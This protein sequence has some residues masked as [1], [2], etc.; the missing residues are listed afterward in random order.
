MLAIIK[1]REGGSGCYT[2]TTEKYL[3]L[4]LLKLGLD[5]A[6]F[7]LCCQKLYNSFLS[8][9][10]SFLSLCSLSII[11]ADLALVIFMANVWFLGA[12]RS[13]VSPCFL[14]ANATATYGALPL[15]M[16][17][18]GVLDYCLEDT[19]L[20]N[21]SAFCKFLRNAVLTLLVWMLAVIHSFGS[22]KAQLIELDYVTG[23]NVQVC[24]IEDSP[25]I[26]YFILGL[27]TAVTCT[28]LPFWSRI[29][30]W[31]KEANR[32]SEEREEQEN[33]KSDLLFTSS[34][35]TDTKWSDEYHLEEST[36][37]RPPLWLSLTLGFGM[38][39]MPYLAMSVV[40]LFFGF[41][42]PAYLTV[43]LLWLECTHSLLVGVVFWVK[44]KRLGPYSHLPENVCSWQ[45]YWHLSEGTRQQQL[46]V[47]VCNQSKGKRN[48][49]YYV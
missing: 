2:E 28:L 34:N 45:I 10:S 38:F 43:N 49:L 27:F 8:L 42:V 26:A 14:L 40:C 32:L 29:P 13:H 44:S 12:E 37:P 4:L 23:I 18:L 39:W 5:A 17:C 24:E 9:C 47:A 22:V 20:E 31:V 46:P 15:P 19:Y 25:L 3:F 41:G 21:Q 48:T 35:Y 6:V 1:Q 16:M 33:Q 7:H 11:M 36:W 30:Q